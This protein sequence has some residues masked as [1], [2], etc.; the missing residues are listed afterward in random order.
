[1]AQNV[2]VIDLNDSSSR[3]DQRFGEAL[4]QHGFAI[5]LNH[6]VSAHHVG[7]AYRAVAKV[8]DLPLHVKQ[9]YETPDNGRLTGYTSP[10]VERA[11]DATRGD[12]KEFW[13]VMRPGN[14]LADNLF[15]KEVPEFQRAMLEL[16]AAMEQLSTTML[17]SVGRYL[18]KP[19]HHFEGMTANGNSVLRVLHYPEIDGPTTALRAAPH[20]DIN[21]LTLLVAGTQP[22]LEI[23]DR[24]GSWLAV[25]TPPDAI[26]ANA[27]DMMQMHTFGRIRSAT[28]RVVNPPA[29]D[30]GRYSMPFF[31]HPRADVPLVTAGDYLNLRLRENGVKA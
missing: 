14:Q 15:P 27:A 8:F 9:A 2:P 13:H 10:E 24:D 12:V 7:E 28:H 16:F 5:I 11:K 22:G 17:G 30:G 4:E 23:L 18:G 26:I 6:G 20:E 25:Q 31:T 1:M 3:V 21:L 29:K 19:T